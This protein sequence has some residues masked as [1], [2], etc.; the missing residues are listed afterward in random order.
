[1]TQEVESILSHKRREFAEFEL[2]ASLPEILLIYAASR[3]LPIGAVEV[4][5]D[6]RTFD[7]DAH[8]CVMSKM[9]F[10]TPNRVHGMLHY[11]SLQNKIN[12]K[13]PMQLYFLGYL[14]SKCNQ[15]FLVPDIKS[16]EELPD[17]M[18]HSC[19]D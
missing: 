1:M 2:A 15:I 8:R 3:P 13:R 10:Y 9:W 12:D 5:L 17:K 18:R 16:S 4:G 7:L 6:T 19:H 14:C 11:H